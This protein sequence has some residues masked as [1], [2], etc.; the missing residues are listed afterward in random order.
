MSVTFVDAEVE[1]AGGPGGFAALAACERAAAQLASARWAGRPG[2][3]LG[4]ALLRVDRVERM[5]ASAKVALVGA[6]DASGHFRLDQHPTV[7]TW[8]GA[9]VKADPK[10][11]NHQ[12]FVARRLRTMPLTERALERGTI[13]FEHAAVLARANTPPVAPAFAE[14]EGELVAAARALDFG[15][16]C[17]VVDRWLDFVL[18]ERAE[19][20]ARDQEARR[21]ASASRTWDGMVRVDAWL[22]A[23]G[24]TEFLAELHRLEKEMF[25]ADWAEARSRLGDRATAA[26]LRRTAV[27]R[28]ADAMV[29]MARRSAT[30]DT[31]GRPPRWVLNV[32]MGVR[33][34]FAEADAAAADHAAGADDPRT[35]PTATGS[36]PHHDGTG[37]PAAAEATDDDARSDLSGTAPR[38]DPSPA[39]APG[40][41]AAE[42]YP[43]P[44]P[45]RPPCRRPLPDW[46]GAPD[47]LGPD[48]AALRADTL[49]ELEDQTL[50][51]PSQAL[52]LGL[53]GLCR[54]IVFG[55]DG[56]I[57]DFGQA[58]DSFTGP[59]REAIVIRDRFCTD[60]GCR[61]PGRHGHIDHVV[62]RSRGGPTSERNG[63]CQCS[64]GNHLKG[65]RPPDQ[66]HPDDRGPDDRGPDD[67][68]PDARAPD[69]GGG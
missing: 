21:A 37:E 4:D 29:E 17:V 10:R 31:P 56:H 41:G 50:I 14:A 40:G 25:A 9:K 6:F 51:A 28:R 44:P 45:A 1:S 60:P 20:R 16:F 65:A 12:R 58:R 8:L 53:A 7:A 69:H 5:V 64:T 47:P 54:R 26:D 13:G 2:A 46:W 3:A 38:P 39:G 62:P 63:R 19:K 30:C 68:G 32:M 11:V 59:L 27:Q 24:G 15:E 36:G 42:P 35:T 49:C 33:T 23:I 18:P 61:V 48:F 67:R 34:F 57:L 55:P 22:D 66:W 52:A 43:G